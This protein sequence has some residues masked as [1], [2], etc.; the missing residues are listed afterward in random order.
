MKGLRVDHSAVSAVGNINRVDFVCQ[1]QG[2]SRNQGRLK[3]SLGEVELTGGVVSLEV[4]MGKF[5][6]SYVLMFSV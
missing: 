3:R 1:L 4:A 2:A 5:S 6:L